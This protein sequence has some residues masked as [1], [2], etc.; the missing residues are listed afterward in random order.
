MKIFDMKDYTPSPEELGNKELAY[1]IEDDKLSLK[2]DS[3]LVIDILKEYAEPF[4]IS[5][6]YT[7]LQSLV[8]V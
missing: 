5:N 1:N 2:V 4:Y 7:G 6:Q 3:G 8:F